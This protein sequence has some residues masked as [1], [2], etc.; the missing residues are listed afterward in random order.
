MIYLND[1][2]FEPILIANKMNNLRKKSYF[3]CKKMNS[4]TNLHIF[5][6][7]S[8]IKFKE[9]KKESKR[10]L[11]PKKPTQYFEKN[12]LNQ[13]VGKLKSSNS[14]NFNEIIEKKKK[15]SKK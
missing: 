12:K 9:E 4:L 7:N 5:E 2:K 1:P 10:I 14:N 6:K 13:I 11:S 15:K 8:I 3:Y